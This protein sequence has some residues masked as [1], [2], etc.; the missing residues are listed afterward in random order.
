MKP[1][2]DA[3]NWLSDQDWGWWPLLKYRPPKSEIISN[4]LVAKLTPL[5]GTLSGLAIAAIAQ[6]LRS[7]PYLS[8]DIAIGWVAYFVIY[9]ASFVPAWNSRAR[10]LRGENA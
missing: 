1:I 10:S 4:V 7:V 2:I 3:L 5:F 9:R 8:L 6:H